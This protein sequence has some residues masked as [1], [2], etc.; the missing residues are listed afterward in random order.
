MALFAW[1]SSPESSPRSTVSTGSIP[2]NANGW[3][4]QNFTGWSNK[5]VDADLDALDVEFNAKKRA[6]LM[7][8]VLKNYTAEVPVIPLYYRSDISVVPT[9]MK[10]YRMTGHQFPETNTVE[11]WSL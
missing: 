6:S 11:N 2:T 4:G 7:H 8:N 3:S 10:N 5:E 1:V 9:N